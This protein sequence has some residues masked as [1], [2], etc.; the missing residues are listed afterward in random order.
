MGTDIVRLLEA[1]HGAASVRQLRAAGVPRHTVDAAVRSGEVTRLRRDTL[2]LTSALDGAPPW[3]RQ[4]LLIRAVGHSLAPAVPGTEAPGALAVSHGSLLRLRSLPCFGDDGL[5]HLSRVGSGS[6]R[7]DRTLWVHSPVPEEFVTAV[8]GIRGVVP[9][10]AALQVAATHGT[11]AG[12]VALD[13]VLHAAEISDARSAHLQGRT[14]DRFAWRARQ[15]G[16]APGPARA[17]VDRQVR[18]LVE[19]GFGRAPR[20]VSTVVAVADGRSESVG[21]SR[22]R[23]AVHLLGLGPVTPQFTV[24]DGGHVVGVADLGLDEYPVLIEFDGKGKYRDGESLFAEKKREDHFRDLG[25]QVVRVTWSDL[26]RP[27]VLRDR[28][29]AAI[30]RASR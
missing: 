27:P 23:W 30:A 22:C 16:D 13:G 5:V 8:D 6:G 1:Q 2:V 21:E 26:A 9:A 10:L 20:V 19:E 14:P 25:Y 12:V 18:A 3:E 28:I 7:R 11:E 4:H 15:P 29:Q 17:E 24:R